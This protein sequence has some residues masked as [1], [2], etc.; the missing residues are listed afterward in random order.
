MSTTIHPA[1][2]GLRRPSALRVHAI[3]SWFE[4][5][6]TLRTPAF[7]LPT[8]LFPLVF[9]VVFAVV[10]PGSWGGYQNA[11]MRRAVSS[12]GSSIRTARSASNS[13]RVT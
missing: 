8:L 12:G 11:L 6:R 2:A 10:V 13:A 5:L 1:L 7:A 4:F 9:Y 3:E